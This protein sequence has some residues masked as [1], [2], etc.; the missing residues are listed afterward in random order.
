MTT[1]VKRL[2]P[3]RGADL[4]GGVSF[5]SAVPLAATSPHDAA[6]VQA[7]GARSDPMPGHAGRSL[8][9][10][11]GWRLAAG[12]RGL[13]PGN[14]LVTMMAR[15]SLRLRGCKAGAR[16]FVHGQRPRFSG[17]GRITIGARVNMRCDVAPVRI[18]VAQGAQVTLADRVF[19]NTG[20]Q[21]ISH[22]A[23]EI[24]PNCRI[25]PDCVLCDTNY[26]PVHEGDVVRVAPI[27]LGRNV[28]LGRGVIVLPGVTIGDH[29]VVA[30]GSV[31]AADVPASQVW[32]GN[33][34]TFVK[35]VRCTAGYV[36]P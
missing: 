7:A 32:R 19:L 15:V 26:H 29:A 22:A 25:G 12:L 30:A 17:P 4:T 9:R 8:P 13:Q 36:R 10:R 16:F 18:E 5:M 2:I 6:I 35:A 14:R 34:A 27:R 23:I 20:A 1:I 33:P 31:V 28:W 24:G 21:L 11:L 3:D